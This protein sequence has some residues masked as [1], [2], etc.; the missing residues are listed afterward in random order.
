[1][2]TVDVLRAGPQDY[3]LSR[4]TI[5]ITGVTGFLGSHLIKALDKKNEYHII[6]LK[7]SFSDTRRLDNTKLKNAVLYNIDIFSLEE[8][9]NQNKIDL[10]IHTATEYGRHN[11]SISKVIDTNLLFPI[12]ILELAIAQNTKC[13]INTDSY[14][15]KENFTYNYLLD[16]ALSKKSLLRW[17]DNLS[18]KIQVVNLVLEHL[19]GEDDNKDK[20]IESMITQIAINKVSSVDLTHGHQRRDYIYIAD[21]IDAYLKIIDFT[22]KDNS[23]YTTFNVGTGITHEIRYFVTQIK[24]LSN[25]PTTLNFGAISYRCDEIMES[26]ADISELQNICFS[27]KFSIEQGII[28]IFNYYKVSSLCQ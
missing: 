19:Y 24:K 1:M 8:L 17:L 25:S 21:A 27:P 26:K 5:L 16:Y 10:I 2:L 20:F 14:F 12:K 7:R 11:G 9:F 15:N 13:F 23:R 28:S 3:K 6:G 22:F 4:K 18:R